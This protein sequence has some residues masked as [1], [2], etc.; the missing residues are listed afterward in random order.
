MINWL[1]WLWNALVHSPG[2]V[3][4]TL[5]PLLHIPVPPNR[6]WL[7]VG[8]LA[9]LSSVIAY[10]QYVARGEL[11]RRFASFEF[12]RTPPE[13]MTIF[14]DWRAG[15]RFA[16]RLTIVLD[17][18]FLLFFGLLCAYLSFWAAKSIPYDGW[19]QL[20]WLAAAGVVIGLIALLSI[21]AGWIE[22]WAMWMTIRALVKQKKIRFT[23]VTALLATIKYVG[24]SIAIAFLL[25]RFQY[26]LYDIINDKL[27]QFFV[28]WTGVTF[29]LLTGIAGL[30]MLRASAP[31]THH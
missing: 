31:S 9:L 26:F 1:L 17:F 29:L 28:N 27:G 25:F 6:E 24:F 23:Y 7:V 13:A 8:A 14:A 21:F 12:A 22:N 20:V 18:F 3:A 2:W 19:A 11:S 10:V 15:G 5:N 30:R 16:A 4:H